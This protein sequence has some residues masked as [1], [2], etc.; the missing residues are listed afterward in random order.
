ML[1]FIIAAEGL[2]VVL[3]LFEVALLFVAFFLVDRFAVFLVFVFFW[4]FLLLAMI[5]FSRLCYQS[6]N[7]LLKIF[8]WIVLSAVRKPAPLINVFKFTFS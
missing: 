5:F 2:F 6:S 8:D 4:A 1:F 7:Y 3:L